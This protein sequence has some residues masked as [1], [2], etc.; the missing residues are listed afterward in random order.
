MCICIQ[1]RSGTYHGSEILDTMAVRVKLPRTI[2]V[3][4]GSHT[5][6]IDSMTREYLWYMTD[7]TPGPEEMASLDV[8]RGSQGKGNQTT[9]PRQ[10]VS[11]MVQS[12]A[13]C[14]VD[15]Q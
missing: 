5:P 2:H 9:P 6:P 10:D 15:C 1:W 7:C 14:T 11:T 8:S 12:V 4:S 3:V 13:T